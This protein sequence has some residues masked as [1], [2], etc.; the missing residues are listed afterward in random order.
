MPGTGVP[1]ARLQKA[2]EKVNRPRRRLRGWVALLLV[3]VVLGTA[4]CG[5]GA[6]R[7]DA[8]A[9][10]APAPSAAAVTVGSPTATVAASSAAAAPA[11]GGSSASAPYRATPLSPPVKVSVGTSGSL[12]NSGIFFALDKGYF[13]EEG[14]EVE[15][16]QLQALVDFIAALA[17]G[18]MDAAGSPLAAAL[19]NA[20]GQNLGL[21]IVADHGRI[22][23]AQWDAVNLMVRQDLLDSGEIRDYA[24]LRGRK[25]ASFSRDSTP[26]V[27]LAR[28][29]QRG[30]LTLADIEYVDLTFVDMIAAFSNKAIDCAIVL[31]PFISTITRQGTAAPWK[32]SVD[33]AGG[34]V[35]LG[36]ILYG[37]HMIGNPEVA[38]RW[39][40]AYLRG[41][42]AYNDAFGP[43]KKDFADAVAILTKNTAVKDPSLYEQMRP[44][45]LDPDGRVDVRGMQ[46]DL[47]YYE[48]T[49]AVKA[50]VDLAQIVDLSYQEYA[51]ARLGPY[52]R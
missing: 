21:R 36:G 2:G 18:Q 28:A 24:D 32:G 27:L 16:V 19:Y 37:P 17:S 38:R 4:A 43:P 50:R 7:A 22:S 40:I 31:E 20:A 13:A 34:E 23:S 35:Q 3:G 49:G 12:A 42:R 33:I 45:G 39:M 8:P 29:L 6:S 48:G 30:G 46:G 1:R 26:E 25:C 9:S 15:T 10:N 41:L 5:G 11:A 52:Q 47:T 14:L 51:L 44:F